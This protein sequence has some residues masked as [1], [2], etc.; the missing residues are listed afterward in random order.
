MLMYGWMVW[1]EHA[2]ERYD[3]AVKVMTFGRIDRMKDDIAQR[4]ASGE[5]VLDIGCGTGTLALRC[6][7]RGA[8]VTGLDASDF[9][10]K[11]AARRAASND[12]Q[13]QLTL[14]RDS[15]TQLKKHP[16]Q[17]PE[18]GFDVVTSTMALGEFPQ[19]YLN[20]ILQ[21]CRRLLRP[22]GR[23]LIGDECWPR[24]IAIRTLYRLSM[25]I[26]WIPQFLLLRRP[27]FPIR[28][29]HKIIEVAGFEVTGSKAYRG[30]SFRLVEGTK[31]GVVPPAPATQQAHQQQAH[32][33]Q[34][35]A[36]PVGEP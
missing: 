18:S 24:N 23:V 21:D 8:Q 2:P 16:D 15:V 5:K 31:P 35:E 17:L 27:L 34:A 33:R 1:V 32:P 10:L 14:I 29:L 12:A 30:T 22:G 28:D 9:M 7:K 19:E 3:W 26:F 25:T 6:I 20:Y 13:D 11:E 36:L 4:I